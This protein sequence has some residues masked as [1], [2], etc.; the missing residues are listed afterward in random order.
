MNI[1]LNELPNFDEM[2]IV[3]Q[4]NLKIFRIHI[5]KKNSAR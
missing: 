2:L 1:Y 4:K 5:L 3:S